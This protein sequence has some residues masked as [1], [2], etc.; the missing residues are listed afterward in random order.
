MRE[1]PPGALEIGALAVFPGAIWLAVLLLA[2]LLRRGLLL[3]ADL[4]LGRR[5]ELLYFKLPLLVSQACSF[6]VSKLTTVLFIVRLGASFASLR[7]SG[8]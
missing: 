8:A 7:S 1:F 6:R 2:L 4:S 5:G 3:S